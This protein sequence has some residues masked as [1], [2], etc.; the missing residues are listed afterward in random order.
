MLAYLSTPIRGSRPITTGHPDSIGF[1]RNVKQD[2]RASAC[3]FGLLFFVEKWLITKMENSKNA[4]V[5]EVVASLAQP[6]SVSPDAPVSLS[7]TV[8]PKIPACAGQNGICSSGA[9]QAQPSNTAL[10]IAQ[11]FNDTLDAAALTAS[12]ASTPTQTAISARPSAEEVA[13]AAQ[14]WLGFGLNVTILVPGTTQAA[15]RVKPDVYDQSYESIASDLVKHPDTDLGF[16]VGASLIVFRAKSKRA[17]LALRAMAKEHGVEAKAINVSADGMDF[18]FWLQKGTATMLA[19]KSNNGHPDQIE[20]LTGDDLVLLPPSGGRVVLVEASNT[21][22]LDSVGQS[23]VDEIELYNTKLDYEVVDDAPEPDD[24]G[25]VAEVVGTPDTSCGDAPV[26]SIAPALSAA[27]AVQ[28]PTQTTAPVAAVKRA[29]NSL[30]QFNL[31]GMADQIE[32]Q[33]IDAVPFLGLLALLGQYTVLFAPPGTGKTLILFALL[34][35]AINRGL[36]DPSRVYYV[37]LDDSSK[38]LAE[39]LRIAEEYGFQVQA[40]G[41]Q[42]F[43]VELFLVSLQD[44]TAKDQAKGA[45]VLLDTIKKFVNV[46]DKKEASRFNRVM[47]QFVLKGGTV[48]GLA[49]TNKN[50]G[51]NGKPVYAGTTDIRDDCDCAWIMSTV[52]AQT[53]RNEKIIACENIKRRGDVPMTFGLKYSAQTAISYQDLLSSVQVVDD[54]Q[55]EPI[56]KAQVLKSDAELIDVVLACI[57]DGVTT[58][59]L[60][61]DAVVQRAGVSN[62]AALEVIERYCG[63]DLQAHRWTYTVQQRGAKVFMV[64]ERPEPGTGPAIANP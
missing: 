16:V 42:G 7:E 63:T 29:R 8:A 39:K 6:G 45:V 19:A 2:K 25:L 51:A 49:H 55:L 4:A 37:D 22:D 1:K 47:R 56:K 20:V 44:M 32:K 48:V 14:N 33:A 24:F 38:G 5:H 62:R 15:V 35:D 53:D 10:P 46:M 40:E 64:L 59:M 17:K 34:I 26:A 41:Y 36:L 61:R 18:F 50:L 52:T 23:V 43:S 12:A 30:D 31:A 9:A 28:T 13:D 11:V 3:C 57:K 54:E 60:L 27:L 21:G 58:K